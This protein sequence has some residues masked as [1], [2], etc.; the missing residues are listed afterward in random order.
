MAGPG[1]RYHRLAA[2]LARSYQVTLVAPGDGV[3]NAPYEF[4]TST[5]LRSPAELEPEVVVAQTL[6]L[7][8]VRELHRRGVRLVFDLYAPALVEAAAQLAE[9]ADGRPGI[10]YDE[11]LTTIRVILLV[12]DAFVC[13]SE[14]QRDHWLGALAGLGR[15]TPEAYADDPA[16]DGLVGIVP[17]GLDVVAGPADAAVVKGVLPGIAPSD[18]LLLWGGGIWD[19]FDP[20]TVIRAT[21]VLDER[22]GDVR[23]LFLGLAHPSTAVAAMSMAERAQALAAELGLEGRSVFFNRGWVPYEERRSWFAEADIGVSAHLDSLESRLAYR[24]RLLD[25]IA[26][27]TPLVVTRG[28]VLADLVEGTRSRAHRRSRRRPGLGDRARRAPRGRQRA[29]GGERGGTRRAGRADLGAGRRGARCHDRAGRG[30]APTAGLRAH[31]AC[32]CGPGSGEIVA[33]ASRRPGDGQRRCAG[34]VRRTTALRC[35]PWRDA[36]PSLSRCGRQATTSR[37]SPTSRWPG[38]TTWPSS[39]ADPE[40]AILEIGCSN[41]ATG[42]L[43]LAEGKCGRYCGVELFEGPAAVARERL[44]EV[45]VGDVEELELPWPETF[46]R[47]ARPERGPRAPARPLGGTETAAPAAPARRARLRQHAERGAP[48]DHRH[49]PARPLGAPQLRAA[50]RNAPALVHAGESA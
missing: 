29:R 1:I 21:G 45:V 36:R 32:P 47:C 20:L 5:S 12:G 37:T 23:L 50:R 10:R 24:T 9:E 46:I 2:E 4:R 16:L 35:E 31:S 11:V 40:A 39:P 38:A 7:G 43:A 27:G 44:T 22:R 30:R 8:L 3:P 28:D 42:A 48:R 49:A 6:P 19:W 18:R 17:F 33:R 25:H 34:P 13:A 15:V 26:A 41:G 14:R